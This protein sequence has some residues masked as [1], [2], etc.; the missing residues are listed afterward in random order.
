MKKTL[1]I[2]AILL[3][4]QAYSQNVVVPNNKDIVVFQGRILYGGFDVP[5]RKIHYETSIGDMFVEGTDSLTKTVTLYH[6]RPHYSYN[7][8]LHYTVYTNGD[9]RINLRYE[10][11]MQNNYRD[12]RLVK[13]PVIKFTKQE[14]LALHKSPFIYIY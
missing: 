6:E 3:G 9:I 1:L 4:S 11:E 5:L 13:S 8:Y 7:A 10:Q 2:L 14:W 12:K